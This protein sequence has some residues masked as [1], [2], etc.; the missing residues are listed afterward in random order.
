MREQ[1]WA[2]E[3]EEWQEYGVCWLVE[4]RRGVA[5]R[6]WWA[7]FRAVEEVDYRKVGRW[8]AATAGQGCWEK[9]RGGGEREN[10]AASDN[11]P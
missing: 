7:R 10:Q 9:R 11:P 8:G 3:E 4:E 5:W 2:K 1:G 6:R